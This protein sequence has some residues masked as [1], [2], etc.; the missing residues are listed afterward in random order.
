MSTVQF[1]VPSLE[2]GV[3]DDQYAAFEIGQ[4]QL[5]FIRVVLDDLNFSEAAR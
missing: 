1:R 4:I 5:Q 2:I 3:L